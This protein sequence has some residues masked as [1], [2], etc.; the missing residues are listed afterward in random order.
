MTKRSNILIGLALS[1]LAL[2]SCGS[3]EQ[4]TQAEGEKISVSVKTVA[5]TE[6][7]NVY[8]FTGKV[9]SQQQA[10]L[11]TRLMGQVSEVLVKEGDAVKAGDLLVKIR[12]NDIVAKSQQVDASIAAAEAAY[13]AASADF[14][15]ITNLFAQKSATQ[16]ELDD[17]TAHKEMTE[18]NLKAAQKMKAEINEM[19]RY[20]NIRAPF[21]GTVTEK[22]VFAGDMA[23]PGMPLVAVEAPAK[24]EVITRIPESDVLKCEVGDKVNVTIKATGKEI[25]GSITKVSPS[26]KYTGPQ[27]EAI[28]ELFASEEDLALIRSGMFANVELEKGSEKAVMIPQDLIVTRGQ[29]SGVWTVTSNDQAMMRWLRLGRTVDGMVEVLSGLSEGEKLITSKGVR[30]VDGQMVASK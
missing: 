27:Y 6:V 7:P 30:F 10:T 17:I 1:V 25:E 9:S 4:K 18:A 24:F 29:L 20:A 12:S 26:N 23:N 16:K 21:D 8:E 15:R 22:F 19:M 3:K 2:T 11:S 28:V 13:K 14:E 5:L